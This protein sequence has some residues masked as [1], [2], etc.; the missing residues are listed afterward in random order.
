MTIN[1]SPISPR[2]EGLVQLT[3]QIEGILNKMREIRLDIQ[4]LTGEQRLSLSGNRFVLEYESL[5][6]NA[7]VLE[8]VRFIGI[9]RFVMDHTDEDIVHLSHLLTFDEALR[10]AF[11][12]RSIA[13]RSEILAQP[14]AG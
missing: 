9:S 2:T 7:I 14:R 12:R 6:E 13:L 1:R 11:I 3:R 10:E 8:K 4:P 5:R